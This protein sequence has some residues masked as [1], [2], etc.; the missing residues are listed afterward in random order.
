MLGFRRCLSP[1]PLPSAAWRPAAPGRAR[2]RC[3]AAPD[4]GPQRAAA[5][6]ALLTPTPDGVA[7]LL[8]NYNAALKRGC[9]EKADVSATAR[10][11]EWVAALLLLLLCCCC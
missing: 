6:T 2:A 8:D 3:A 7:S 4:R 1:A 5:R 10:P 9:H 11:S